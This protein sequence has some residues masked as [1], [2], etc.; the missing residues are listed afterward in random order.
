VVQ[1][2]LIK[3]IIMGEFD[4]RWQQ[5]FSNYLKALSQLQKF[6]DKGDAL[7][8]L[9]EQG[10]IKA[11]EYTF[12]LA[13]NTMKDFYES[14]GETGIQGSRDAIRMA[15]RRGLIE[16]G[17]NWMKMIESRIRTSHTYNEET[18]NE[19]AEDIKN[20]YFKL[21]LLLRGKLESQ[22]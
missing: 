22:E 10:L 1:A 8:D 18:A 19:I 21:F 7:N 9:E 14:Q 16:D 12:E 6:I 13:W 11:F 5:R 17:D 3:S 20:K 4:I 2:I 15:F